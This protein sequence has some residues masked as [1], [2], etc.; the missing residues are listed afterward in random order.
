MWSVVANLFWEYMGTGLIMILYLI[1]LIYLWVKEKR[2]YIRIM[3]IYV[4]VILLFL[5]F[6]PLFAGLLYEL[7]GDEIYYRILWLLPVTVTIA[8]AATTLYSRLP[9][10]SR[11]VFALAAVFGI[12]I[13]GSYI[14]SNPY[15]QKA[16]NLY[17]MPDSV[18]HICDAIVV[19]GR[20]VMA[21]FPLEMVQYVRQYE[22]TVCMPYGREMTV[23]RWGVWDTFP[24]EMEKETINLSSLAPLSKERGC[25]YIILSEDKEVIG[26]PAEYGWEV[27]GRTDGYVIYRD[28]DF[29][30]EIGPT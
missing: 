30:L 6:N 15:F 12:A 8:F 2:K 18:V 11:I 20:E 10:K 19:P 27:F 4:P 28:M 17:H 24:N 7:L 9:D 5:Y 22:P 26:D 14:Y 25:H 23:D 3:L 1:S 13:S 21:A 16:E 29:S